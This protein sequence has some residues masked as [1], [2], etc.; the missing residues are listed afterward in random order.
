MRGIQHTQY[1]KLYLVNRPKNDIEKQ[2]IK[3]N[4]LIH[5]TLF[6]SG[7]MEGIPAAS[8]CKPDTETGAPVPVWGRLGNGAGRQ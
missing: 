8:W 5:P 3:I 1:L 6:M 7:G 2:L 4:A